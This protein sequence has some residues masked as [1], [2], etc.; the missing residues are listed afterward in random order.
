MP[1][2]APPGRLLHYEP[3]SKPLKPRPRTHLV[4]GVVLL[5]VAAVRSKVA[6]RLAVRQAVD[7]DEAENGVCQ[8]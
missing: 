7:A 4:D 6:Q 8:E 3:T 2:N 1:L 5:Q